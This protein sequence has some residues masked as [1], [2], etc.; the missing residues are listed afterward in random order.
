MILFILYLETSFTIN[1]FTFKDGLSKSSFKKLYYPHAAC[2]F[3][4]LIPYVIFM[5]TLLYVEEPGLKLPL[6]WWKLPFSYESNFYGWMELTFTKRDHFMVYSISNYI[7]AL[8]YFFTL[9]KFFSVCN[10]RDNSLSDFGD[11]KK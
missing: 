10:N 7:S 4:I 9:L 6:S 2:A 5:E 3:G 8:F 11:D 1:G